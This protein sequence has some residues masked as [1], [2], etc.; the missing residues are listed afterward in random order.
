MSATLQPPK[1][2]L[3]ML[4]VSPGPL[5]L[6][7]K[8]R[9]TPFCWSQRPSGSPPCMSP[10]TSFHAVTKILHVTLLSFLLSQLCCKSP[11][12]ASGFCEY[13]SACPS[14]NAAGPLPALPIV[15]QPVGRPDIGC[16]QWLSCSPT[17][18]QAL[19]LSASLFPSCF[20]DKALNIK[21]TLGT[22]VLLTLLGSSNKIQTEL[23]LSSL[24]QLQHGELWRLATSPFLFEHGVEALVG[25]W[26]LYRFRVV[27]RLMGSGAFAAF[28]T[29]VFSVGLL[30]RTAAVAAA[31][32]AGAFRSGPFELI[33]ALFVFY[34]RAVPKLHPRYFS[35]F[36]FHFSEKSLTYALGLQLLVSSGLNS[37]QPGALGVALGAAYMCNVGGLG[38]RLRFPSFLTRFVSRFIAPLLESENPAVAAERAAEAER[39]RREA[40][41]QL[42]EREMAQAMA[43]IYG[44]GGGGGGEGFPGG[45]GAGGGGAGFGQQGPGRR[46]G[47]AGAGGARGFPSPPASGGAGHSLNSPLPF[48]VPG[49]ASPAAAAQQLPEADAAAVQRL[50]DMGFSRSAATRALRD[51]FNDEAAAVNRLVDGS[52][53]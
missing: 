20:A 31:G 37:L 19:P 45:V 13:A 52:Y 32:E 24:S 34:H 39:R 18:L 22:S 28:S 8:H 3:D 5:L 15:D 48:G 53:Q 29:L 16:A 25:W 17:P 14:H 11:T 35:L 36:N 12:M 42:E 47:G 6:C 4:K 26:L 44:G 46:Q 38:Q 1:S 41:R 49:A 40:E 30:A 23:N 7:K 43:H 9:R 27:E 50:V 2:P 10:I 51:A 21:L 33:F